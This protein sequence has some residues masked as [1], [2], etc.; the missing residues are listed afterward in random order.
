MLST[1]LTLTGLQSSQTLI[2]PESNDSRGGRLNYKFRPLGQKLHDDTEDVALPDAE[3][4]SISAPPLEDHPAFQKQQLPEANALHHSAELRKTCSHPLPHSAILNTSPEDRNRYSDSHASLPFR[5]ARFESRSS[6]SMDSLSSLPS[7][8][9][10]RYSAPSNGL[11]RQVDHSP[12]QEID[13]NKDLH[14]LKSSSVVQHI[15][16]SPVLGNF[17]QA[18]DGSRKPRDMAYQATRLRPTSIIAQGKVEA[19]LRFKHSLVV[20]TPSAKPTRSQLP[21]LET[22]LPILS[23]AEADIG[24]QNQP[25]T[26]GEDSYHPSPRSAKSPL[27]KLQYYPQNPVSEDTAT[28][29][30]LPP[31]KTQFNKMEFDSLLPLI[32]QKQER[33]SLEPRWSGSTVA[34][35]DALPTEP[36]PTYARPLSPTETVYSNGISPSIY[37]QDCGSVKYRKAELVSEAP[38]A[39]EVHGEIVWEQ[40][41][42]TKQP[43]SIVN[44][45]LEMKAMPIWV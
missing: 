11:R 22:N 23:A 15:I 24:L 7:Q 26:T 12:R 4:S 41:E 16:N 20:D 30:V 40:V 18:S 27:L 32:G 17:E 9:L 29:F 8:K 2:R 13:Y 25:N 37:S 45:P 36:S 1:Y 33:P 43:C 6:D 39:S 31:L 5:K 42:L 38:L 10:N 34:Y 28:S 19:N 3:K 44:T 14:R 21:H 35:E